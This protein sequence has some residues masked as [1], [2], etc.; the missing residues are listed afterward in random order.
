MF[1]SDL[2]SAEYP[3][4]SHRI[5]KTVDVSVHGPYVWDP[6]GC[7]NKRDGL[8]HQATNHRPMLFLHSRMVHWTVHH[9]YSNSPRDHW[10][11]SP[12]RTRDL[13]VLSPFLSISDNSVSCPLPVS[14][15]DVC[16]L[17]PSSQY[18]GGGGVSISMMDVRPGVGPFCNGQI[19]WEDGRSNSLCCL[20]KQA[21]CV[22]S[23]S[24]QCQGPLC[25]VA[26]LSVPG[27]SVSCPL[28]LSARDLCVLSPSSQCQGPLCPVA[29]LSVPGTS[30]SCPLPLSARDLCVLSPSSQC[31]GPLCPV[32]F[33]SARDLC[34][35]SPSSQCQG[36]LCPVAFLSVPGTS[37]SCRLPLSARDL[38]VLSPSSQCQGPLCPVA[39]LS[40]P[41][42][43]VSC[44]LPLSTR[45]LCVLSPSS[46]CQGPLCPVAFLSV[47][48]TFVFCPLPLSTRD[49]CVLSP[50]SQYQR[51]QGHRP[52]PLPDVRV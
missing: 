25:P 24:S 20:L 7:F 33:L 13:C 3:G 28:P 35:L 16:V 44:P 51:P 15:R 50:S 14:T 12:V 43:F 31:Q 21:V 26:F 2:Y 32:A 52:P 1:L 11:L 19:T 34:V 23:P 46:Q 30:V 6:G 45:D 27:T 39:F 41:G 42:T 40:V 17:S 10:V 49:L 36:P 37:V 8:S 29:F 18:R 48:G 4:P 5:K 22:L 9:A 47:P 38:C